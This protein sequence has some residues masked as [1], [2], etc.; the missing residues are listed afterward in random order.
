MAIAQLAAKYDRAD[1]EE[2]KASFRKHGDEITFAVD[3]K[4]WVEDFLRF[5]ELICRLAPEKASI[6]RSEGERFFSQLSYNRAMAVKSPFKRLFAYLTVYRC[7]GYKFIPPPAESFVY[8]NPV[9]CFI[10]KRRNLYRSP[11][12]E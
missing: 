6:L 5:L 10:R 2:I 3:V 9:S 8:Q 4:D 7:F 12:P 1:V 11:Y